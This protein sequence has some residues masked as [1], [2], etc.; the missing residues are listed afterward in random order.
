MR[1]FACSRDVMESPLNWTRFQTLADGQ[2]SLREL[3]DF[4]VTYVVERLDALREAVDGGDIPTVELIAHQLAGS[5]ATAGAT[6]LVAPLM[7]LEQM[8]HDGHLD[9]AGESF[10]QAEAAFARIRGFL[11]QQLDTVNP[12]A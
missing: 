1:S 8:A 7:A 3:A 9:G 4:Y 10:A 6:A 11:E 2:E 12:R 5:N